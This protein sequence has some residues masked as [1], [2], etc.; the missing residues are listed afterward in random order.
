MNRMKCLLAAIIALIVMAGCGKKVDVAFGTSILSIA[1]EGES[2]EVALTSNGD[3]TIDTYPEWLTVSPTSG[4]GNATL[5]LTAPLNDSDAA[6]SGELK[7]STKDN[8]ATL[9]VSQEVMEKGFI[10]V[11]PE[12]IDCNAEGGM[13]TLT[14]NS[15]CD[16][17][18]NNAANW[19]S[20]DPTSG[21]GN[22]TVTVNITPFEGDVEFRE[23]SIIFSGAESLLLPVRVMQHAPIHYY[24]GIDPTVLAF[25]YLGGEQ[26][27]NVLCEGSWTASVDDDWITLGA[28]SGNGN[29]EL[30][31]A[32]T[33]NEVIS[34]TRES[35]VKFLSETGEFVFLDIKQDGAPDPHYLEVTPTVIELDKNG[36]V[37]EVT[38]S[39]NEDWTASVQD[40]WVSLSAT[41]G[42]GDGTITLTAEPNTISEMRVTT[43]KVV[44]GSLLKLVTIRQEA[45]DEPVSITVSPDT[46]FVSYMGGFEHF[47]I[48]ANSNWS[49]TTSDSWLSL[50]TTSGSGDA[51][52]SIVVDRNDSQ[53]QR[54]GAINIMHNVS[55]VGR[56]V[57]V[58]EG[59]P[60][61]LETDVTEIHAPIEGGS[62]TVVVTANQ[63]WRIE[64]DVEWVSCIPASG[65]GNGEFL[66]KIT[67]LASAQSRST[68][69]RIY[70]GYGGC[71]VIP[72]T[73]SN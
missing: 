69:L 53:E 49:L 48:T 4:N 11:T 5:T 47:S 43:L 30:T 32:V 38:I 65:S 59:H 16:W 41:S 6:R 55:V 1:A 44:S 58:Q 18:V 34:Q 13:F 14:V 73:Q 28:T 45:G 51:N 54:I 33:E 10:I 24:I 20:C 36:D 9:T 15:N 17:A 68:E 57:V 56:V 62:Y 26:T 40:N 25:D 19:L 64:K 23:T 37:A 67:P 12:M 2:V 61:I 60:S 22:G 70:G 27:V 35:K 8:S 31:V 72:V 46:L 39:C 7:V 63:T 52:L 29:M 71:L 50:T 42:T 66:I 21:T 3:W